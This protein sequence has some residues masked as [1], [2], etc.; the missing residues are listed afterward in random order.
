MYGGIKNSSVLRYT[1]MGLEILPQNMAL[2]RIK[3]LKEQAEQNFRNDRCKNSLTSPFSPE[4]G[5][6]TLT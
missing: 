2:W 4:A 1:V 5:H 3:Y 6:K